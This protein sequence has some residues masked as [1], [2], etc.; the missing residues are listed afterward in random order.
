MVSSYLEF[1][2]CVGSEGNGSV[3]DVVLDITSAQLIFCCSCCGLFVSYSEELALVSLVI[4]V[5]RPLDLLL[6]LTYRGGGLG[7]SLF[8]HSLL[9]VS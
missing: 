9:A 6:S 2:S 7:L 3:F 1:R 4:D 8:S 5:C